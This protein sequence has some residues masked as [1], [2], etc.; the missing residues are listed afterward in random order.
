[1][2]VADHIQLNQSWMRY[3]KNDSKDGEQVNCLNLGV[4]DISDGKNIIKPHKIG[5]IKIKSLGAIE[6]YYAED[7][8]HYLDRYWETPFGEII[9][10]IKKK[11]DKGSNY[12]SLKQHDEIF[13][14][15]FLAVNCGRS[16]SNQACYNTF[17]NPITTFG[18][19]ELLPLS[20]AGE[21]IEFCKTKKI[22]IYKNTSNIGFVLPS[23][24]FYPLHGIGLEIIVPLT[25]KL[26]ISFYKNDSADELTND[27][28]EIYQTKIPLYEK[29]NSD[30]IYT[31]NE[32]ALNFEKT[33][34]NSFLILKNKNDLRPLINL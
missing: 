30:Y 18:T 31:L 12:I 26:A 10:S 1:M 25:D 21:K 22:K 34:N 13:I 27:E 17:V 33:K 4:H 11:A 14:K 6:N 19:K 9:K 20:I 24:C 2:I 29:S 5:S 16:I 15:R 23:T 7:F 8:E 28:V 32:N 3:F